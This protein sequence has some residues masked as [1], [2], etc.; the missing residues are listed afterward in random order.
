LPA[1]LISVTIGHIVAVAIACPPPS[2]PMLLLQSPPPS[3]LHDTFIV[4][5]FWP[6]SPLLSAIA[7]ATANANVSIAVTVNAATAASTFTDVSLRFCHY[8][9]H[10]FAALYLIVV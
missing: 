10:H 3:S 5:L 7:T 1:G 2:L 4:T 6:P 8:P 9:Y